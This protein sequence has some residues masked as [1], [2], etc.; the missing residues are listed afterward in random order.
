MPSQDLPDDIAP[1][2]LERMNTDMVGVVWDRGEEKSVK[3]LHLRIFA[4]GKR[5]FYFYYV[6]K[7]GIRRRPKI[8]EGIGLSEARKRAAILSSQV[9]TGLDPKGEW[10]TKRAEKTVT[11]VYD[12]V[13]RDYWSSERFQLSGRTREVTNLW[14]AKI[15]HAFGKRKISEVKAVE[16]RMWHA[17]MDKTPVYANRCLEVLGKIFSYAF[18][19]EWIAK[20]PCTYV[21]AFPEKKR[22]RVPTREELKNILGAL[23]VIARDPSDDDRYAAIYLLAL[24]YTGSR[25]K[26][27]K[28]CKW[29]HVKK[30]DEKSITVE[31]RGKMSHIENKDDKVVIPK[32]ILDLIA[33][34]PRAPLGKI[35][36][37]KRAGVLWSKLMNNFQYRDL[38]SRDARKAFASLGLHKGISID[39]VG[40]ALN[41]KSASTTKTYAQEFDDSNRSVTLTIADA[42]DEICAK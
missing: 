5:C 7:W 14:G 31:L 23:F 6:T 27:L 10:E 20:S 19:Q 17:S 38:W 25:P 36:E 4:T 42:L 37:H 24:F 40:N 8:G 9:A 13:L 33:L 15:F 35:F 16:I 29:D 22:K 3:G 41:H 30:Q 11:E 1:T 34:Y 28:D 32:Q 2:V 21:K 12:I 18:E 39:L 26:L